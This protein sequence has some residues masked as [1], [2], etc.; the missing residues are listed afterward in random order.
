MTQ[1]LLAHRVDTTRARISFFMNKFR[2][3]GLIDYNG[4]IKVHSGRLKVVHHDSQID[5]NK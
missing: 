2:R 5:D 3:L 1:E 4:T